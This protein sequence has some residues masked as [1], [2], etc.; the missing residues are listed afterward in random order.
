MAL[1]S[2][3]PSGTKSTLSASRAAPSR[4]SASRPERTSWPIAT[5]TST[6]RGD[7]AAQVEVAPAEVGRPDADAGHVVDEPGHGDSHGEQVDGV[8]GAGRQLDDH[9]GGDL[10]ELVADLGRGGA[11]RLGEDRAVGGHQGRLDPGA[12][13]VDPDHCFAHHGA[14]SMSITARLDTRSSTFGHNGRGVGTAPACH[15]PPD[16]AREARQAQV[17]GPPSP[18][19]ATAGRRRAARGRVSSAPGPRPPAVR[20]RSRPVTGEE[21][22]RRVRDLPP[23][24]VD[25]E[26]VPASGDLDDLGRVG[27]LLLS[28]VRGVGDGPRHDVVVLAADDEQRAAIGVL[29]STL[30]SVRGLRFAVAA[31]NSGRPGAATGYVR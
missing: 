25:D 12:A 20:R 2:P 27:V 17:E 15:P 6:W 11:H 4:C 18:L 5:G 29:V 8:A 24:A 3:V 28:L 31:W 19:R 16:D 23:A 1:A 7:A 22:G 14:Q 13:D 26:R 21:G 30:A 9:L 10:A